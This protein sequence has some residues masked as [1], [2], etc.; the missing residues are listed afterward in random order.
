MSVIPSDKKKPGR[1]KKAKPLN[2]VSSL[3]V[4]DEPFI[5]SENI[6]EFQYS[7]SSW[8]IQIFT[9]LKSYKCSVLYIR[10]LKDQVIFYSKPADN[11]KKKII[12]WF[13]A[14]K[15]FRYYCRDECEFMVTQTNTT[16]YKIIMSITNTHS[17]ILLY[18]NNVLGDNVINF[19]TRDNISDISICK[20]INVSP[21]V[22]LNDFQHQFTDLDKFSSLTYHMSINIVGDNFKKII[23]KYKHFNII[24]ITSLYDPVEKRQID[25]MT[26]V[27]SQ[28][29][30]C[31]FTMDKLNLQHKQCTVNNFD[32][33]VKLQTSFNVDDIIKYL[34]VFKKTVWFGFR[35]DSSGMGG[36]KLRNKN[37]RNDGYIELYLFT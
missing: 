36:I 30:K 27:E 10:F 17:Y 22:F 12:C 3:G 2:N 34:S 31:E 19:E 35:D 26:S 8:I 9:S 15:I 20:N 25:F 14:N 32:N 21:P 23:S 5:N 1:P 33:L 7:D 18:Y 6:I 24:V 28:N 11:D 29:N 13:D 4:V 37:D 16:L